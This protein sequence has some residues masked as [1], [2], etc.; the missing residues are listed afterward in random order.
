MGGNKESCLY[1]Q[2]SCILKLRF[3]KDLVEAVIY[4]YYI[5]FRGQSPILEA[6]HMKENDHGLVSLQ[7]AEQSNHTD[8][9]SDEHLCPL[10]MA[11]SKFFEFYCLGFPQGT[12]LLSLLLCQMRREGTFYSLAAC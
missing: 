2:K 12:Y 3:I 10:A 7:P 8:Q 4:F 1:N 6:L 5:F 11:S 9:C